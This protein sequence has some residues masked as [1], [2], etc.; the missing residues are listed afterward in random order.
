MSDKSGTDGTECCKKVASGMK[1]VRMITSL[2][3]I[4]GFRQESINV[5]HED[6]LAPLLTNGND[7]LLWGKK[8]KTEDCDCKGG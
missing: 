1:F 4:R 6:L 5:L 7:A 8:I 3:T 2:V